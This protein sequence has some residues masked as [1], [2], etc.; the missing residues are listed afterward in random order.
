VIS[1]LFTDA[2]DAFAALD[3]VFDRAA[4]KATP[5]CRLALLLTKISGVVEAGASCARNAVK[6]DL[7]FCQS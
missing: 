3:H 6:R 2:L 1:V 4:R 7:G 5:E